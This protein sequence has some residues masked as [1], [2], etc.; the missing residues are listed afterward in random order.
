MRYHLT[1]GPT[2]SMGRKII[3]GQRN[4]NVGKE[5]Q[6]RLYDR[7]KC[8]IG[9]RNGKIRVLDFDNIRDDISW[10]MKW[11]ERNVYGILRPAEQLIS[12][13]QFLLFASAMPC[14][15]CILTYAVF[16]VGNIILMALL[17]GRLRMMQEFACKYVLILH[18][19]RTWCIGAI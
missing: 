2:L 5:R 18:C 4:K 14:T 1:F 19:V 13:C 8:S 6:S 7:R 11:R 3:E 17:R 15:V 12:N 16:N 9:T 10:N